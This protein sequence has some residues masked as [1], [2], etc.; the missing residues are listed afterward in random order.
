M[1]PS[2]TMEELTIAVYMNWKLYDIKGRP[3]PFVGMY[4]LNELTRHGAYFHDDYLSWQCSE[5]EELRK[6][7]LMRLIS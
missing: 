1:T 5:I 4:L 6:T 2:M 7:K 3:S